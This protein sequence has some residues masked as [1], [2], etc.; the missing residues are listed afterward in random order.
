MPR[1][2]VSETRAAREIGC[3]V[4]MLRKLVQAGALPPPLKGTTRYDLSRLHAVIEA[5]GEP[6]SPERRP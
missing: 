6:A 5:G 3:T 4:Y 2:L 1:M